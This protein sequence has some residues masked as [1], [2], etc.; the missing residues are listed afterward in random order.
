MGGGMTGGTRDGGETRLRPDPLDSTLFNNPR[1]HACTLQ[2]GYRTAATPLA[3]IEH[4]DGGARGTIEHGA[5]PNQRTYDS[6]DFK[7]DSIQGTPGRS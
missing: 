7:R 2:L 5:Q 1:G 4:R 6:D 3:T